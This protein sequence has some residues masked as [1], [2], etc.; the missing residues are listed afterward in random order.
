MYFGNT[1][2]DISITFLL[3][4][5][6]LFPVEMCVLG[7]ILEYIPGMTRIRRLSPIVIGPR[8]DHLTPT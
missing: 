3:R 2:V 6:P 7:R 4:M 1:F 5:F 8:A